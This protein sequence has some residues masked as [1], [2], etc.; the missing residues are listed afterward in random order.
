MCFI[1]RNRFR[2]F[3]L[4]S[5]RFDGLAWV[6]GPGLR[7]KERGDE[8]F[9]AAVAPG[10]YNG[11]VALASVDD[12]GDCFVGF[13]SHADGTMIEEPARVAP[14]A[15]QPPDG[16]WRGLRRAIE[17]AALA[18]VLAVVFIWRRPLIS[19]AFPTA[20]GQAPAGLGRRAG[21]LAIDV[22]ITLPVWG[23]LLFMTVDFTS[24]PAGN[25]MEPARQPV[26]PA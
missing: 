17:Y 2:F 19:R 13:W 4:R 7:N 20:P 18:A 22:L 23:V 26:P 3:N 6:P 25:W 8:R 12:A 16:A 14:L 5:L 10:W 15:V 24:F 1:F 11:T 21:A 9:S